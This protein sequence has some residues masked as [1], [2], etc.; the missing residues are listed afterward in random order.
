MH[1]TIHYKLF[2]PFYY[3]CHDSVC[4]SYVT[5]AHMVEEIRLSLGFLRVIKMHCRIHYKIFAPFYYRCH[6][7]VCSSYETHAHIVQEINLS[8]GFCAYD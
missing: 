2:A 8:L 4:S 5:H 7:N 6:D 3:P 1:Y